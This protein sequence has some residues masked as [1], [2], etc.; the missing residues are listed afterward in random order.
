MMSEAEHKLYLLAK[1]AMTHSHSPYSQF[2]V[3][4]AILT[5]SGNTY[6]G[7]NIE[8]ASYG[9]TV[10]AERV[11]IWKGVSQEHNLKI[12]TLLVVTSSTQSEPCPP[13]GMCRQVLS[14]FAD[15]STQILTTDLNENAK[16]FSYQE[17]CPHW[18]DAS[19]L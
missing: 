18:F 3:G 15:E 14:E 7:T 10:C 1:E 17:V 16:S 2:K 6:S 8:N 12:K 19:H 4:A 11:A 5:T 9:A 13:C